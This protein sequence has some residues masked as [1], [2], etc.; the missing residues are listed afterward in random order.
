MEA[1]SGNAMNQIVGADGQKP[2]E[3]PRRNG[4]RWIRD[5]WAVVGTLILLLG[6]LIGFYTRVAILETKMTNL[7]KDVTEMKIDMKDAV[8][9]LQRDWQPP[10]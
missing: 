1:S 10:R 4:Q 5:N 8:K 3:S 9:Y 2:V 7:Q 6:A